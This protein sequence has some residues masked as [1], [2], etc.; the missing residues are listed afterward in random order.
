MDCRLTT[1]SHTPLASHPQQPT[2]S[3]HS[4]KHRKVVIPTA[5][6]AY[7]ASSAGR[8]SAPVVSCSSTLVTLSLRSIR[9]FL[10]AMSGRRITRSQTKTATSPVKLEEIP[11]RPRLADLATQRQRAKS[12]PT[13]RRLPTDAADNKR[14]ANR[15][16]AFQQAEEEADVVELNG[17]EDD[18][19]EENEY[20]AEEE[21]DGAEDN[22]EHERSHRQRA[23]PTARQRSSKEP[24][25]LT[26]SSTA[27]LVSQL[28]PF[29]WTLLKYSILVSLL[30]MLAAP[31]VL[32]SLQ[33]SLMASPLSSVSGH[34]LLS[35]LR[36]ALDAF[37]GLFSQ[38]PSSTT[39]ARSVHANLSTIV[40]QLSTSHPAYA[41]A[42]RQTIEPSLDDHFDLRSQQSNRPLVFFIAHSPTVPVSSLRSFAFDLSSRL[43]PRAVPAYLLDLTELANQ[44]HFDG[45]HLESLLERHFAAHSD[46][47]VLLPSLATLHHSR[48]VGETLQHWLDDDRAPAKRAVFIIASAISVSSAK[49]TD[50]G[51]KTGAAREKHLVYERLKQAMHQK[52]DGKKEEE[53]IDAILSRVI[54]N[55]VVLK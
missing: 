3:R 33:P 22:G 10:S 28:L 30:A 47:L 49:T 18:E 38:P 19:E 39:I 7:G 27:S 5:G 35:T 32:V 40:R 13:R 46:G 29:L 17:E 51:D 12:L 8:R 52:G 16:N 25:T 4:L 36:T 34:S 21:E 2:S 50:D 24:S 54:R 23:H 26:A 20:E 31:L 11:P 14:P 6:T 43:Y 1:R 9:T 42:L 48:S 44:Q 55:V 45:P 41:T 37:T 53:L 15:H